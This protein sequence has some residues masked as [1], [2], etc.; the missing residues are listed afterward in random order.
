MAVVEP[1]CLLIGAPRRS[2]TSERVI[3]EGGRSPA[4]RESLRV[5]RRRHARGMSV[6]RAG[7]SGPGRDQHVLVIV[8]PGPFRVAVHEPTVLVIV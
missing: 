4:P 8:P 3:C 1:T 7:A 6:G 2:D 5:V